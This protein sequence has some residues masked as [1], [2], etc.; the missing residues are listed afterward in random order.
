MH[1]VPLQ[2]LETQIL[3]RTVKPLKTVKT[4]VVSA[5]FRSLGEKHHG[6]K[7]QKT[8]LCPNV[9]FRC[10][11]TSGVAYRHK[12]HR[13]KS[14]RPP[15]RGRPSG[16]CTRARRRCSVP[17]RR[18][19]RRL[20]PRCRLRREYTPPETARPTRM[21]KWE[22]FRPPPPNTPAPPVRGSRR[23]RRLRPR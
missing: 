20:S 2:L 15:I 19:F 16:S 14:A 12:P 5:H 9:A 7:P 11:A 8:H 10:P 6:A 4:M 17:S 18:R 13:D 22:G 21:K 3:E 23:P 1:C